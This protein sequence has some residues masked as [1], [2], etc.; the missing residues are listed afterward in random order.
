MK[1]NL[2]KL[3]QK[4][5]KPCQW[6]TDITQMVLELLY[7]RMPPAS[8]PPAIQTMTSLVLPGA[9]VIR[10]LPSVAFVRGCRSVLSYLTKLLAFDQVGFAKV[11]LQ[12]H[13]DGTKRRQLD[14]QNAAV[15][16][17][18]GDSNKPVCINSA[19]VPENETSAMLVSAITRSFK[20]GSTMLEYWRTVTAREYPG[21]QDL[22]DQ[23]AEGSSLSL[24]KFAKGSLVMTDTCNAA[25]KFRRLMIEAIKDAAKE[26]GM[27]DDSIHVFEAD[28][29][30]HLRNV[31]VGAVVKHLGHHLG[32]SDLI[33]FHFFLSFLSSFQKNDSKQILNQFMTFS[34]SCPHVQLRY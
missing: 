30:H 1:S 9:V 33:V 12:I 11:F 32:R 14:F 5:G 2:P 21:R 6:S 4:V 20:E 19:I 28:C 7:H 23:I 26:E 34:N 27:R 29:W 24:A 31:W 25:R 3:I 10:E 13:A 17:P 8:I 16:I 18:H 22:L 15:R